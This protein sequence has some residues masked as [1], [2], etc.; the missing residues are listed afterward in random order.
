M[1]ILVIIFLICLLQAY[2]IQA[3]INVLSAQYELNSKFRGEVEVPKNS[4]TY[5]I[6]TSYAPISCDTSPK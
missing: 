3:V 5:Q 4:T 2:V 1:C 6:Q